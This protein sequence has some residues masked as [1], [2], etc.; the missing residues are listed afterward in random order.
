MKRL[1]SKR[2][3]RGIASALVVAMLFFVSASVLALTVLFA[4]ELTRTRDARIHAQQ[5]QLL[6]AGAQH[7]RAAMPAWNGKPRELHMPLPPELA[8]RASVTITLQPSDSKAVPAL[9]TATV[10]GQSMRQ[11]IRLLPGENQTWNVSAATLEGLQ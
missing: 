10:D 1:G 9:I 3:H 11:S 5:R 8:A 7:A 4:A 6:L 2:D